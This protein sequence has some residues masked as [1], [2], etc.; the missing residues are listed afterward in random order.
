MKQS[1]TAPQIAEISLAKQQAT[2]VQLYRPDF[3]NGMK[4]GRKT[5]QK[6]FYNYRLFIALQY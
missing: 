4:S 5:E 6:G 1:L 3:Y 2:R